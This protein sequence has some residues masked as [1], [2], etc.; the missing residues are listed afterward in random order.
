MT[1]TIACEQALCL[2]KK[3]ILVPRSC[4]QATTTN[5]HL[6][7]SSSLFYVAY[8]KSWTPRKTGCQVLKKPFEWYEWFLEI[9]N[10]NNNNNFRIAI[11]QDLQS[12]SNFMNS[13]HFHLVLVDRNLQ[14]SKTWGH[15]RCARHFFKQHKVLL[16]K[17]YTLPK[18]IHFF[19]CLSSYRSK[20]T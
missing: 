16:Y 4:S 14:T 17:M 18:M 7:D 20:A 15:N 1:T 10:N 3:I 8:T 6:L 11:A 2:G 13:C 12:C 9:Y 5:D 19:A